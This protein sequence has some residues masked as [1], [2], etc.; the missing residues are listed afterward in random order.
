MQTV[1]KLVAVTLLAHSLH[2]VFNPL[3]PRNVHAPHDH[4]QVAQT[5]MLPTGIAILPTGG[6][7]VSSWF[8][9]LG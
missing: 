3:D 7:T 9:P 6:F 1:Y 8:L 2:E 5:P 4:D